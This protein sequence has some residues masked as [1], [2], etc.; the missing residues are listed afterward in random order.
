VIGPTLANM[1]TA[2]LIP[3][4]LLA[5]LG[6]DKRP[7]ASQPSATPAGNLTFRDA[8]G[9][10]VATADLTLPATLP[11]VGQT[12]KG[13]WQIL[14]SKPDFPA[15]GSGT[16][17]ANVYEEWVSIDLTPGMADNNVVFHWTP[18][19]QPITGPWYHATFAGGKPMGTFSITTPPANVR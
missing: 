10:V 13:K 19:S 16:Y 7:L 15:G 3:L 17:E 5:L 12:F 1:R 18:T 8:A 6:C 9:G 11:A 2:F 4:I 14:S